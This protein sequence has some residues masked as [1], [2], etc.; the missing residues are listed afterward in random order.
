LVQAAVQPA[1]AMLQEARGRLLRGWCRDA[2]ARDARGQVALPWSEEAAS[3]SLLGALLAAWQRQ[4][5][6]EEADFVAHRVDAQGLGDATQAL[7][8]ATGTTALDLW[9]DAECRNVTEVVGAVDRAL[10]VLDGAG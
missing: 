4:D 8:K 3:W 1:A 9:N 7:S 6:L 2:Q 5:E 10:A